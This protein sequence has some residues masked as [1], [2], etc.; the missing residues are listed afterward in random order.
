ML[1][2]LLAL[3]IVIARLFPETPLAR[4]LHLH[5]VELPLQLVRRIERRHLILLVIVLCAGQ[6]LALAGSVEM[7][8][9]YAAE[10]SAYYDALLTA[11][12]AAAAGR[13]KTLWMSVRAG[14]AG[15]AR[16]AGRSRGR[17]LRRRPRPLRP[18]KPC[19]DDE[20]GPGRLALA[21]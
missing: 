17:A 1:A 6:T 9:A 11:S 13:L 2:G 3:V 15:I 20:P 10:M 21:A 7:G 18:A 16:V 12:F 5:F 19:N 4:L 8:L 14:F